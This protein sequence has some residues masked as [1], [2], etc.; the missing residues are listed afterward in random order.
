M[1]E[2]ESPLTVAAMQA[3][4]GAVHKVIEEHRRRGR[5]LAVWQEE[6]VVLIDADALPADKESRASYGTAAKDGD[7]DVD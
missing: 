6:R 1:K 5:P 3:M 2:N 4:R 7:T